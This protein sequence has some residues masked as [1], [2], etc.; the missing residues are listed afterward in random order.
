MLNRKKK[1]G[2][3][4]SFFDQKS[5]LTNKSAVYLKNYSIII[6]IIYI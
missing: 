3:F 6:N 2:C 1:T 5:V 4:C